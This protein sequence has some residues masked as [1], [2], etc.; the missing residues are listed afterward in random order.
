MPDQR[1]GPPEWQPP[2]RTALHLPKWH[3]AIAPKV[4]WG[5]W[6]PHDESKSAGNTNEPEDR[7]PARSQHHESTQAGC[8]VVLVINHHPRPCGTHSTGASRKLMLEEQHTTQRV[9]SFATHRSCATAR[10][11]WF[12]QGSQLPKC[13]DQPSFHH[14]ANGKQELRAGRTCSIESAASGSPHGWSMSEPSVARLVGRS[15]HPWNP[16]A[17]RFPKWPADALPMRQ[18]KSERKPQTT[19]DN[20][21]GGHEVTQLQLRQPYME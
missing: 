7:R 17:Q 21:V 9:T 10:S 14:S 5:C 2:P 13:L 1:W 3:R 15:T 4:H 16:Q 18:A 11:E 6:W 12:R 20:T 8:G 19:N